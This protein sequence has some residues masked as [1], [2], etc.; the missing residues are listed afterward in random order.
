MGVKTVLIDAGGVLLV[1]DPNRV[2]IV[3]APFGVTVDAAASA[4]GHY[5]GV[6]ALTRTVEGDRESFM[7]YHEAF[8]GS[9]G[10]VGTGAKD[11]VNALADEFMRMPIFKCVLPGVTDALRALDALGMQL[12]IVTNS[13]GYA[14]DQLHETSV[15]QVGPGPL[16]EVAAV[17]DSAIVGYEKPDPRIFQAALDTL[18][19]RPEEAVYVGDLYDVDVI[20]ARAA[21][22][23]AVLLTPTGS[24]PAPGCHIASSLHDLVDV[25]LSRE[26]LMIPNPSSRG[27]H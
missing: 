14:E 19:V 24:A 8:V 22:L 21:G 12:A 4:R 17:F 26:A 3:L 15:C 13:G 9:C 18:G 16:P 6:A 7:P 23:A 1:P 2:A 20:G 27:D 5:V 25:L 10:V 11:A